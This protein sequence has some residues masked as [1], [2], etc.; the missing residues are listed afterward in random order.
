MSHDFS[1]HAVDLEQLDSTKSLGRRSF[2]IG[3]L[4]T[5]AAVSAPINY[6]A[7]AK[8]R[9]VPIAKNGA[10]KLGVASGYPR[11]NGIVLWTELSE[12]SRT[13]KL[14]VAVSTD[15][16]FRKTVFEKEVIANESTGFTTSVFVKKLKPRKQ[17]YYRFFTKNKKSEVGRFRTAPPRTRR[18]RSGSPTSLA[19]TTR[20]A[21][22]TRSRRSPRRTTS[23]WSS[24]SATTCTSTPTSTTLRRESCAR[25][26]RGA[27]ATA[28]SS[29]ST[30][31]S[32]STASTSPTPTSGRCTQPIPSS[33]CG[34]TT[35]SRTTTPTASRARPRRTRTRRT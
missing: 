25:T 11:P 21:S 23:T 31:T 6:A 14:R 3:A 12:I 22:S 18:T 17:Y 2:L 30:S 24:A 33:R 26:P 9:R 8:K 10:F 7:I 28:T 16:K 29:S 19:R 32:R 13:S 1:D 15:P 20:P 5:G 27:T 4:A 34:M 35:R